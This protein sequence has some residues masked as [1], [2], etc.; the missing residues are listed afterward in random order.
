MSYL[1]YPPE[2]STNKLEYCADMN[3]KIRQQQRQQQ[4]NHEIAIGNVQI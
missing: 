1:P 4:Q 2:D 3:K